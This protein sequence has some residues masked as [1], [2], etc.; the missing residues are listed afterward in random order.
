MFS[1]STPTRHRQTASDV[2]HVDVATM[3]RTRLT[4]KR[5]LTEFVQRLS[6][7]FRSH[8]ARPIAYTTNVRDYH[9]LQCI[10]KGSSASV[11]AVVYAPVQTVLAI[12]T[13][14]LEKFEMS[15]QPTL[16]D[17]LRKEIQI[18]KLCRHP[19]LLPVY[20]C[21]VDTNHLYV[22]TP[23]MSAGSCRDLLSV[24]GH[25]LDEP[26]IACV[27][28]QVVLGL[29]YLHHQNDLV[30]RDVKTAN[31][32]LD[33]DTGMV[34]L[35]DFGV[36]SFLW[37]DHE[38]AVVPAPEPLENQQQQHRQL[39]QDASRMAKVRDWVM[40]MPDQGASALSTARVPLLQ[41]SVSL[42][43][44]EEDGDGDSMTT[45]HR[46]AFLTHCDALLPPS[47]PPQHHDAQKTRRATRKSFVGTPL[48]IA[49][50][51][52]LE[53][54]YDNKVDMWALGITLI[55]LSDGKP[56]YHDQDAFTIFTLVLDHPAPQLQDSDA[57]YA[58]QDFV[59]QCLHKVP[60]VRLS[61]TEAL[62]HP[63][64]RKAPPCS[65]LQRFLAQWPQMDVR[66]S[67]PE[68]DA[69][70]PPAPLSAVQSSRYTR[71]ESGLNNAP[72]NFS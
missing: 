63:F 17:A 66:T 58:F 36:S 26:L 39:H 49:P 29:D 14:N 70:A 57:S 46:D 42:D 45:L 16:L 51:I 64:L 35:A 53:E 13:I 61:A 71:Y 27:T 47:P 9:F 30:H 6:Q 8:R 52:L 5:S 10:G 59:D 56:P 11:F 21:F 43:G 72:W 31:L 41:G 19:H 4:R 50:E 34:K 18:M 1:R 67:L 37:N 60:D 2:S 25:G 24:L 62:A 3:N 38:P 55:E 20:Q 48:Y 32:L 69:L 7:P 40:F 44:D 28:R 65:H 54:P 68:H 33:F 23:L 15:Q 12:K 22:I